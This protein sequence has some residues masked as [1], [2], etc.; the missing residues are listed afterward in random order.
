[1]LLQRRA[2]DSNP[3][4]LA[5]HLISSQ[6]AGQFAYP[7]GFVNLP[8]TVRTDKNALFETTGPRR[9]SR[10]AENDWRE[11]ETGELGNTQ[12][13]N[14]QFGRRRNSLRPNENLRYSASSLAAMLENNPQL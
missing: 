10:Q 1:M 11:W 6:T 7:P 4:P 8:P 9:T 14:E 2:W 5:G 13:C 12:D 3:Q